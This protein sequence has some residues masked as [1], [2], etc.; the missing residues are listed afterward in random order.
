MWLRPRNPILSICDA[1]RCRACARSDLLSGAP[2][3]RINPDL[4]L[5]VR[6]AVLTAGLFPA[7]R[8]PP[9]LVNEARVVGF[10]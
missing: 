4:Q 6:P 9:S 7:D 2:A 3:R 1:S 8:P 5:T 10:R